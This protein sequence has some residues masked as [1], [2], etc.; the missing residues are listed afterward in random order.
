MKIGII[1]IS[2]VD[3]YGAELQAYALFK[4]L[5]NLGYSVEIIDYLYYKHPH[6]IAENISRPI[7]NFSILERIKLAL[8]KY[9]TALLPYV[10]RSSYLLRQK[11]FEGFYENINYSK[12]YRSMSSLYEAKHEYDVVITGS[13][14]VWNPGTMSNI[15]PFFLTFVSSNTK[16]ISYASSFGVSQISAE[17]VPIYKA[18]L[19][20]FDILSCREK[21]GVELIKKITDRIATHV[22]DP[23]LLL[24][25]QQ[26]LEVGVPYYNLKNQLSNR[27]SPYILI[28]TLEDNAYVMKVAEYYK[29]SMGLEIVKINTRHIAS[30]N[31]N[32]DYNIKDAGPS[33]FIYLL[34]KASLVLTTS[35]HGTA[36]AINFERP[37]FTILSDKKK[38]NSRQIGLLEKVGLKS[39]II[40]EG[41]ITD[42]IPSTSCDFKQSTIFLNNEKNESMNYLINSINA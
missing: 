29:K 4:V 15:T 21:D 30:K 20:N 42:D 27:T 6:H 41:T 37:F 2:K 19:N 28:Y 11:R 39:R 14:Q 10:D 18:G 25:K 12:T 1:T 22:L 24:S 40:Y 16:K 26:W 32:I 23:T 33:E 35:F 8:K 17:L 36:F 7:S 38:N 31:N 3:N 13:D 9:A 34:S 5:Q